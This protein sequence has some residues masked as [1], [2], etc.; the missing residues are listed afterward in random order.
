M[1]K[2]SIIFILSVITL[3]ASAQ[4][5]G[6][7]INARN[8][9]HIKT[10]FKA[11]MAYDKA[12]PDT[13]VKTKSPKNPS[14]TMP[15]FQVN[16]EE[17]IYSEA[18]T[19]Q[20]SYR[21]KSVSPQPDADFLALED[22][23]GSI[24]PDV[25]GAVGPNHLMI[26]LNTQV[27]IQTRQ[28]EEIS[29][30]SLGNFWHG[31]PGSGSTFDPKIVW[32]H[33]AERWL[34]T[35][36][37]GSNPLESRLFVGMSETSDP[38]GIWHLYSIDTDADNQHWFD[39]PNMGFN[40]KWVAITGN[41]FGP[42]FYNA[43]FVI[44]KEDLVNG[45]EDI[46]YSRLTYNDAF[47]IVPAVSFDKNTD[48]LYCISTGFGN[49]GGEG[50]IQK[51]K[52]SGDVGTEAFTFEG[53]ITTPNP[54]AG[55]A[56]DFAPQKDSPH[57]INTVD[58]RME[59]VIR[60]NDKLW[61][62]HHIFLPANNPTHIAIQWWELDINGN[63]L[64]RGRIED[65]TEEI[66][67]AFP[68]IAV[69]AMEDIMIG[70]SS[71]SENQYASAGYAFRSASDPVNTLRDPINYRN[72]ETPY[73]KTFGGDRNR[74]GDYSAT[75]VDPEDDLNLWTIQEYAASPANKWCTW[76]AMLDM[77]SAPRAGFSA[78]E[79]LIPAGGDVIF[80]DESAYLPTQWEWTFEGGTPASSTEE[81]PGPIIFNNAGTYNI[82]LKVTNELGDDEITM[83]DF[84]TVS[85]TLLPEALFE[86]DKK[87]VCTSEKVTFTDLSQHDPN[88]WLWSFEPA[89]ITF[90]EGS[91]AT[92]QNPIVQFNNPGLYSVTL[93]AQNNNGFNT[94]T[95]NQLIAAGGQN[96]PFSEDFEAPA[97]ELDWT[98][99]NPDNLRTWQTIAVGGNSGEYAISM[100]HRYYNGFGAHD[101]LISPPLNLSNLNNAL[102]TFDHAYTQRPGYSDTLMV[103]IS[104]DCGTSWQT[105][106]TL[107]EDGN[108]SY[109]TVPGMYAK[110]T[111]QTASDWCNGGYGHPCHEIDLSP[112]IGQHNIRIMFET[113]NTGSN[114]LFIDNVLISDAVGINSPALSENRGFNIYPNPSTGLITLTFAPTSKPSTITLYNVQGKTI[115]TQPIAPT[116][117]NIVL[118]L[119]NTPPGI[120]F[121]QWQNS[122]SHHV[123]KLIIQ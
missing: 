82:T 14:R 37:S 53:Y 61:A 99:E 1:R 109:A 94:L 54:W 12:H 78:D 67:Y 116:K 10:S 84:I 65:E 58:N 17:V 59:N 32:D 98:I 49:S 66:F 20:A 114:N 105:L 45:E 4:S 31:L 11:M 47:T 39:Y 35:T 90:I 108:G 62:V 92:S 16:P 30:I 63:L 117:G 36:P 22:N 3:W 91:S 13:V 5:A 8:I 55:S 43:I 71:F 74:W 115:T 48:D 118:N 6:V 40:E 44:D 111:P 79:Q 100:Q 104:D 42:G 7:R 85:N 120:Y 86:A 25:N 122:T 46:D 68:S 64:Q 101:R 96:I 24:P 93:K 107:G 80:T 76:W 23:G 112:W 102:L 88:Q 110:F 69:N 41:M 26:T 52:L 70:F 72:G 89:D 15:A 121:I 50:S 34:I 56:G 18:K 28:G 97:E 83:N 27:R 87:S 38:T 123:K 21:S 81:N 19:S 9:H 60:R 113:I 119:D 106:L 33:L 103:K 95:L 2:L 29:T 77:K 75:C 57:K 51:F 73:Y